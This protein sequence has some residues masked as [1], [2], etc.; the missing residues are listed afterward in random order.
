M[1][2]K[3]VKRNKPQKQLEK[4]FFRAGNNYRL[5]QCYGRYSYAKEKAFDYCRRLHTELDELKAKCYLQYAILS[6]N[7]FMFTYFGLYEKVN[8][9]NGNIELWALYCTST[10]DETWKILD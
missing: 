8:K 2:A 5:G 7:T 9:E 4:Q 6:Y 1:M 10:K 3:I